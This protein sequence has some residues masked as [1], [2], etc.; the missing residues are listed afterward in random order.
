MKRNNFYLLLTG[1]LLLTIAA[2]NKGQDNFFSKEDIIPVSV[3]GYNASDEPLEVKLDTCSFKYPF[4][5]NSIMDQLNAYTFRENQAQM[6]LMIKEQNSGKVVL[7]RDIQRKA[8]AIR[9]N[10]L[11]TKGKVIDIPEKQPIQDKKLTISYFFMPT[12]TNYADPVD[13]VLIKYYFTPK[14]FEEIVRIKNV[15]P[16][17]FSTPVT[18]PTFS[19]SGQKYNGQN[20]AVLFRAYIYKAGTNEFYTAAAGY[21]WHPTASTAP[22]PVASVASSAIYIFSEDESDPNITFTKILEQ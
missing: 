12:L 21:N 7:E 19:T 4:A 18:I 8:G 17:E 16:Y 2:C 6:K 3:K 1:A 9:L 14:V 13:I 22:T 15:K 10:F 5:S 20:T 11:Y